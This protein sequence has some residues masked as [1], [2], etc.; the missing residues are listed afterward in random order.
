MLRCFFGR[1]KSASTWARN[2]IHETAATLDLK[3]LTV[4]IAKQWEAFPTLGDMVMKQKPDILIMTSPSQKDVETLPDFKGVHLI[5][6][7]RDI[8]VSGYFSHRN[9]HPEVFGGL[10]WPEMVEHRKRLLELDKDAG[11]MA[12]LEFSHTF[13]DQMS[14]W[15]YHNPRILETRM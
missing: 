11:I 2:I 3:I 9:S 1:H 7:P 6:D 4:H 15:D 14:S 8:I 12:E 5:R 13:L 10:S